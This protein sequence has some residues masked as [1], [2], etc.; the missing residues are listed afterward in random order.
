MLYKK[1]AKCL[2]RSIHL[3][4]VVKKTCIVRQTNLLIANNT[5]KH[6][7][8]VQNHNL[9]N[10]TFVRHFSTSNQ[11]ES[12]KP[13]SKNENN[14]EETVKLLMDVL[15]RGMPNLFFTIKNFFIVNFVIRGSIDKTF[16]FKSFMTGAK[17]VNFLIV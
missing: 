15:P 14:E 9:E 2:N 3:Q 16:N 11:P 10:Q 7:T 13:N 17:H 5:Y 4:Q 1:L 8:I 6:Q 12:K